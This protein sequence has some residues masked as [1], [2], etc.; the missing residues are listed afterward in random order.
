MKI[1]VVGATG[2]IGGTVV[3]E[4]LARDHDVTAVVRDPS[5]LELE[6]DRLS[7]ARGDV[8]DPAGLADALA[9]HDAVVVSVSGRKEGKHSLVP[10]AAGTV[11]AALPQAGV[12]RLV[13][14]G[15][16][17]SLEGAAG[18]RLVDTP[19]FPDAYKPEALAQAEALA[20]FRAADGDVDWTYL[21]P[22]AVLVPGERRGTYR[23][24]GD[25]V[26][27]DENGQSTISAD[28]YAAALMDEVEH[29]AHVRQRF[30]VAY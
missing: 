10:A 5:R 8:E 15:G 17:G 18:V 1:A 27:A 12:K 26:V 25:Q 13:W 4:A 22:A 6:H 20:V 3:R 24:G 19:E 14:V 9:G 21:S 2:W 23:T 7:V 30:T 11:L 29:P 28:D 16:A